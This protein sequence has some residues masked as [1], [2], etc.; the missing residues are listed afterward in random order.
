MFDDDIEWSADGGGIRLYVRF[1]EVNNDIS[2]NI[3]LT[4]EGIII[5]LI[6]RFGTVVN[7]EAATYEEIA[8]GLS[9]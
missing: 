5:D 8:E 6:D 1:G 3:R 9:E 7:T 4:S 2:L